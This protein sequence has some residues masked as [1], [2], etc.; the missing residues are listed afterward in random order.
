MKGPAKKSSGIL[1]ISAV[2]VLAAGVLAYGLDRYGIIGRPGTETARADTAAPAAPAP[3]SPGPSAAMAQSPMVAPVPVAHPKV[4][5]VSDTLE[6]TGNAASVA[7][8]KL[9]ARVV[10]YLEKIHFEDGALVKKNDLLFTVQQDQ[11]KAQLQQAQ[12]QLALAQAQVDHAKIEVVRYTNLVKKGAAT[13]VEVDRW[14]Y[15]LQA[16]QANLMAGEA[17]VA[18]A[19][20]NLGYTEIRA[21]FDGQM[22]KHLIDPGNVVGGNGQQGALA[23]INQ[24]DPIYV[25][26]N[27]SAQQAVQIRANMTQRQL[28]LAQIQQIPIEVAVGNE[29]TF[30]HRG[31]LQYVAP[32]IDP[33]TGTLYLRGIVRNPDRHILPGGFVRLRL[34]MEKSTQNALLVPNNA[35]QEDQGGRYVLV[36]DKNNV[37]QQRYVQIGQQVGSLRVITGGLS[38]DDLVVI[39]ELWRSSAGT[40]VTPQLKTIDG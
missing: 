36:L 13:Q 39:G 17:A 8:V 26:A 38:V 23:V 10:G 31:T 11:Y 27:L 33:A 5:N 4:Q 6:V 14:N 12:A 25:E 28:T 20:I 21:P 32:A 24:L 30:S 15:Q 16:G 37:T 3:A 35:L 1:W 34:P 7:E 18:L 9:L 22:G 2:A 29:R 19:M 40:K